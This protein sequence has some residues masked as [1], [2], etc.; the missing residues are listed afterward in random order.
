MPTWI[1]R[2][3]A[4]NSF[5]W[6]ALAAALATTR[7]G[8]IA[9]Q[10]NWSEGSPHVLLAGLLLAGLL[11][12]LIRRLD[13]RR[14]DLLLKGLVWLG[15]AVCLVPS[16]PENTFRFRSH[17]RYGGIFENPNYQGLFCGMVLLGLLTQLVQ[18]WHRPQRGSRFHTACLGGG[19]A[20]MLVLLLKTY[21]RGAWLA[22]GAALLFWAWP[23]S[24]D[25][26]ARYRGWLKSRLGRVVGVV[27]LFAVIGLWF[28]PF[29]FRERAL[30]VF[31][32][33]DFSWRNRVSSWLGGLNM[34]VDRPGGVGWAQV[35]AVYDQFYAPDNLVDTFAI[36]RNSFVGCGAAAG[37]VLPA[38]LL[39]WIG[40][41]VAGAPA[42]RL[43]HVLVLLFAC[44]FVFDSG[45]LAWKVALP[46]WIL[47][48]LADR[49]TA[50]ARGA[51]RVPFPRARSPGLSPWG[52]WVGGLALAA[53][54]AFIAAAMIT[55]PYERKWVKV[56]DGGR[57]GMLLFM[58]AKKRPPEGG[59]FFGQ[60]E[61][62]QS[63][64]GA[65]LR[66]GARG[67]CWASVLVT[68]DLSL[69]E[70]WSAA[71]RVAPFEA[72]KTPTLVL[73][74]KQFQDLDALRD[75]AVE[76][77]PRHYLLLAGM[78]GREAAQAEP[79]R[80]RVV[81]DAASC[82][83]LHAFLDEEAAPGGEIVRR[84]E[85]GQR[86]IT[87]LEVKNE[88]IDFGLARPVLIRAVLE[89]FNAERRH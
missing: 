16:D 29:G 75:L 76:A 60:S 31:N 34:M 51:K 3:V 61:T 80:R 22:T 2:W 44:S 83:I 64:I 17:A 67:G 40:S 84:A 57:E 19:I 15:A 66:A 70:Q 68:G 47:M 24:E 86:E 18:G 33:N 73:E 53:V 23:R 12:I 69:T 9:G 36:A 6:L 32:V 71:R 79:V 26:A 7:A 5:L 54:L 1:E 20:I 41:L 89:H 13:E 62:L 63:A 74:G 87:L 11:R 27:V 81:D 50:L 55:D 43:A 48:A 35:I 21:S 30:S 78:A 88:G 82:V 37:V 8:G 77:R 10:M 52:M 72:V 85:T 58:A 56:E 42:A 59:V 39:S 65:D 25:E 38:L 49:Q 28:L 4:G 14:L 45:L 46:F